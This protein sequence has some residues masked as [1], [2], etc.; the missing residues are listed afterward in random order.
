MFS[1][2]YLDKEENGR[3]QE[4]SVQLMTSD[5]ITLNTIDAEDPEVRD[6][7][8]VKLGVIGHG[9]RYQIT[10]SCQRQGYLQRV[11]RT[12]FKS[13]KRFFSYLSISSTP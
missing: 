3:L 13:Q 5:D 10:S 2:Q 4:V 8:L 6:C 9:N 1:D 11:F 7:L 12:V